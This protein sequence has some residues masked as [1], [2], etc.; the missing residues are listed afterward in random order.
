MC[1]GLEI[2]AILG[3]GSSAVGALGSLAG[4]GKGDPIEYKPVSPQ[5][6]EYQ[7]LLMD[8]M[9]QRMDMP[10]PFAQMPDIFNQAMSMITPYYTGQEF[11]PPQT[12]WMGPQGFMG[13]GNMY[14][15]GA[16]MPMPGQLNNPPGGYDFGPRRGMGRR[17]MM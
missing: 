1:S 12:G 9:K 6:D 15:P 16:N 2:A 5:M 11:T 7:K 13:G 17:G 8:I 3:A 4:M 10:R 14:G